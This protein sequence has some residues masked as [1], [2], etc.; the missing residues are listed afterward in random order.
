MIIDLK[1]TTYRVLWFLSELS[2]GISLYFKSNM[3]IHPS[4]CL[5]DLILEINVMVDELISELLF[6][7]SNMNWFFLGGFQKL[8]FEKKTSEISFIIFT[9]IFFGEYFQDLILVAVL[10]LQSFETLCWI[11]Y[12]FK[13]LQNVK[14]PAWVFLHAS[15]SSMSV[16]QVF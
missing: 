6:S 4:S 2:E 16:F 8:P 3:E 13:Y 10:V 11:W 9:Q 1:F 14:N 5:I 12:H 7:R 15:H